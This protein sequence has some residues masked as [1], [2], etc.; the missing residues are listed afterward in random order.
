MPKTL[1]IY[2]D[3]AIGADVKKA[4]G[5]KGNII[6]IESLSHLHKSCRTVPAD[7]LFI[8]QSQWDVFGCTAL[9]PDIAPHIHFPIILVTECISAS[10]KKK[11]MIFR[12]VSVPEEQKSRT[13]AIGYNAALRPFLSFLSPLA[14]GAG[15]RA[16]GP[17]ELPI[18]AGESSK[19]KAEREMEIEA[20]RGF[21]GHKKCRDVFD[22]ILS[23]G[24][25]GASAEFIQLKVWPC[26]IKSHRSDIQSYVC[27]IRK[28]MREHPEC[29]HT[30][31]YKD[32]KYFLVRESREET[33]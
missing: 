12:F 32:K 13:E 30:I 23:C 29:R 17:N 8:G 6:S 14:V 25:K 18:K 28:T 16:V 26:D 4:V 33:N 5:R 3:E 22:L 21:C 11:E 31:A 15:I 9:H 2:A 19:E 20:I 1:L 24:E 10:P 27:K 7:A